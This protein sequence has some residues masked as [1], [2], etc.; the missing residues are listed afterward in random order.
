MS[1]FAGQVIGGTIIV[2][3]L[4]RVILLTFRARRTQVAP[5]LIS[6]I[7]ALAIATFIAGFGFGYAR[8]GSPDFAYSFGTYVIPAILA[9]VIELI[10]THRFRT[11]SAA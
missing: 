6:G 2:Y 4:V 11:K 10:R 9:M 5:I 1:Y 3:L 7:V 8:G